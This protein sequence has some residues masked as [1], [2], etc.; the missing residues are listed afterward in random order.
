MNEG[1]RALGVRDCARC[2]RRSCFGGRA[3]WRAPRRRRGPAGT[4]AVDPRSSVKYL[5]VSVVLVELVLRGEEDHGMNTIC[6]RNFVN[7]LYR[8][9]QSVSMETSG[10]L[11]RLVPR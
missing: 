7:V 6:A 10:S 4:D 5:Y 2:P 11:R 9:S 3:R 1:P 8:Y